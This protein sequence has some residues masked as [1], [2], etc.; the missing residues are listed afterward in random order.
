MRMRALAVLLLV[1]AVGAVGIATGISKGT[2]NTTPKTIKTFGGATNSTS[3]ANQQSV[4]FID[5]AV[6]PELIPNNVAYSLLFRLLS[7]R[8]TEEEK[9]RA[10][11]YLQMVFGCGN[12]SDQERA[13]SKAHIDAFLAVVQEFEQRVSPLDRRAEEIHAQNWRPNPSPA[14]LAEL[15]ALQ[16]QKDAIVAELIAS[17]PTRLGVDGAER[18]RQHI[19]ERVKRRTK[20]GPPHNHK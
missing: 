8:H 9:R 13:A 10:R 18:L 11:S 6:N 14:V 1:T 16:A 19:N 20:I 2:V 15:N 7:D 12:C 17:L 5:G 4:G 3:I